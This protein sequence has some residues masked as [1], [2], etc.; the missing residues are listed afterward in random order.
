MAD[1]T[2]MEGIVYTIA[3]VTFQATWR[4]IA[5]CFESVQAKALAQLTKDTSHASSAVPIPSTPVGTNL[6]NYL[7]CVE[8]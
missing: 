6:H 3:D 2:E 7:T 8:G 5:A 4:D 1:Y